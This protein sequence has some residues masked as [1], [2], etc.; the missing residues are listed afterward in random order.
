MKA[1]C[2]ICKKAIEFRNQRGN[3]L[4]DL[5]CPECS[6]NLARTVVHWDYVN[7]EWFYTY[8]GLSYTLNEE[9]NQFDY[10]VTKVSHLQ[11]GE[12]ETRGDLTHPDYLIKGDI[13]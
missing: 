3:K 13:A 4:A 8:A 12:S 1:I 9:K 2:K 5:K 10:R 6:G 11:M 7:K